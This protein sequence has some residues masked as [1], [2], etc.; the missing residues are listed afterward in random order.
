MPIRPQGCKWTTEKS[1]WMNITRH[2]S[3][4]AVICKR[5]DTILQNVRLCGTR[6]RSSFDATG[7]ISSYQFEWFSLGRPLDGK[8]NLQKN[9]ISRGLAVRE[10][11]SRLTHAQLV[12][13][14]HDKSMHRPINALTY[15][16]HEQKRLSR[17]IQRGSVPATYHSPRMY[18][19][20]GLR[21]N[22]VASE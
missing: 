13:L 7:I 16:W 21:S 11:K 9:D 20:L 15:S 10:D 18:N 3:F 19:Q 4:V 14:A 8:L 17:E 6:S 5:N 22:A 1:G 2:P 12:N